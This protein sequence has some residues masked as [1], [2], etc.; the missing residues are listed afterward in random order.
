MATS[1]PLFVNVAH[2]PLEFG[3]HEHVFE[4]SPSFEGVNWINRLATKGREN[5]TDFRQ[6]ETKL[7]DQRQNN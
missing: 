4:R 2:L 3:S 1:L 7:T 5:I 6:N